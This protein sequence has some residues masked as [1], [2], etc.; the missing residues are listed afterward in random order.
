MAIYHLSMK[1]IGRASGR[2]AVAASAYRSGECLTNERDGLTHDFTRRDGVEHSEI[3]IPLCSGAEW[4]LDRS[5]L[6]NAAEA[7]EKRVDARVAREFEIALPHELTAAQREELCREFAR[8]LADRYGTAVDFAIHSPQK[9]SDIRNHHAHL[10]MTTRAV[11]ADGLSD[12]TA[13]ERENKWLIARDLPS[14]Q[15]QLRDIRQSWEEMANE[16]LARAG[17]EI[18]IDH[19][20]HMERGLEIEPSEH[21]GVHATQMERSGQGVARTRVGS[22]TARHNAELI[23][24]KPEQVLSIITGE[25]S[26][27]GRRDVA[28]A[29]HRAIDGVEAFQAAFASVMA[30]PALV[31]LQGER[32]GPDGRIIEAARYST[33]E[34]VEIERGMVLSAARL[35]ETREHDVAERHVEAALAVR[36]FLS[37]EQREAVRCLAG[38]EGISVVVGLAGAGKSTMLSAARDAWERAGYS[39]HGAALSGK[40]AEGLEQSSGIASRTLASWEAGWSAGRGELGKG[41]VFVIDEAGMVSSR[42]LASFIDA[43]E[44]AGAKIVLV[45]DPEQLQPIQA[46]AAFRAVAERVGFA[47]LAQV[48]R[49]AEGWQRQ[50]S[51]EFARHRTQDGLAAYADRGAVRF[52]ETRDEAIEAIVRDVGRDMRE[53]PDGSRLVLAHRRADVRELNAA[54]REARQAGGELARGE[55]AGERRFMTNDGER[56][57]VAGDRVIFLENNRDLGVKNGMLGVVSEVSEGRLSARLDGA[58][59]PGRGR[60]VA[61]VLAEYAAIDHGYATTIHKSQGATVDRAYV[62]ASEGMDRHLSYVA[63]TRHREEA[64]LYAGHDQFADLRELSTRLSRS[65]AK[66]TTLDYAERRGIAAEFGVRSDIEVSRDAQGRAPAADGDRAA[67]AREGGRYG[68]RRDSQA[69]EH[70]GERAPKTPAAAHPEDEAAAAAARRQALIQEAKLAF[71]KSQGAVKAREAFQQAEARRAEEA[72]RQRAEAERQQEQQRQEEVDREQSARQRF[73]GPGW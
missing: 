71:Y 64:R 15:A 65:G 40:A 45:G 68:A 5:A 44:K 63:M 32:R 39:V 59:G 33:R 31:E 34:M 51:Q 13:I 35:S 16:H 46:G 21:M 11:T 47:E 50:A 58:E 49:Q 73:R 29:L 2:S 22:E 52:S 55:D 70:D 6:W 48:R 26:V 4:A 24:E 19:R 1:P 60:E 3:V 72:E 57:F 41:D 53:R 66:E 30:S 25:K 56:A 67:A 20:S 36:P 43:A 27:F 12:K 18:R 23:R 17:L 9:A 69:R 10:M 62:L 8:G 54:I 38:G 37:E 28:R 7:A 42:Q 14:S 61:V